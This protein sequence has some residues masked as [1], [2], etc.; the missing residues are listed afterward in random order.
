MT[1]TTPS[2]IDV[3]QIAKETMLVPIRGTAPLIVHRF[4]EKAK[5]QML[6]AQQ[7]RKNKKEIRDPKA[8]Y[9]A[10]FY[11]YTD[12]TTGEKGYGFPVIAFKAA[13]ISAARLFDKSVTMVGLRQQ[14]F[15][16]GILGDDGQQLAIINGQPEMREDVV[17]L[18]MS[19]TDLRY[20]PVFN[21]WSTTLEITYIKSVLSRESVLSLID[22]GGLTVGVGEWRPERK[23]DF[24]TYE[25]AGDVEVIL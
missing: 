15:A 2:T 21:E 6:D 12:P 18:G 14:L 20:R 22:A 19:G 4:S 25:L 11:T 16:R 10:S 13:T 3:Q 24:G 17:R 1:T 23:G 5:R 8:D 7:G 9:E